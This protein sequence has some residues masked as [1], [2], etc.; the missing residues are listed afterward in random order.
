MGKCWDGW[1]ASFPVR[2]VEA[3]QAREAGWDSRRTKIKDL[4]YDQPLAYA[5]RIIVNEEELFTTR[6]VQSSDE[7]LHCFHRH[8]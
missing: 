6:S 7:Q 3:G 4:G 8:T 1:V 2:T 5:L